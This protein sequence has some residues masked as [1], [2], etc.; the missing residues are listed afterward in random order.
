MKVDLCPLSVYIVW[1][2]IIITITLRHFLQTS[3]KKIITARPILRWVGG[4]QFIVGK[5]IGY[6]PKDVLERR[7]FEPF[8]GAGSLFFT[9]KPRIAFLSDANFNLINAYENIRLDSARVSRLLKIYSLKDSEKFYYKTRD[10]YNRSKASTIQAA[11]FIYIN[12]TCFNGIFRVNKKNEFNVPYGYKKQPWFPTKHDLITFAEVLAKAKLFYEDY[13]SA[14]N[15]T[16]KNDFVYLD[17]PYP[18]LN[19]TSNFN[20]YTI[21]RFGINQQ[22]ELMQKVI[23]LD[24]KGCLIMMSN[25]DTPLI[26]NLY[27]QYNLH[28]LDV[29]RFV[30][31]KAVRHQVKELVITNY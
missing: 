5:L 10:L 6:C 30:T 1:V 12:R 8:L 20:H 13:K 15:R 24:Q 11:R 4:K 21:D 23:E 17:P 25:A 26:R 27:K 16:K 19:G 14:L 29:T 28:P 31:C 7:Y 18:P 9:L 22:E 3:K 2:K